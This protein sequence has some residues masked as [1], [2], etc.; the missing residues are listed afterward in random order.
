[1][2]SR[3]RIANTNVTRPHTKN[4]FAL[5]FIATAIVVLAIYVVFHFEPAL[6]T[7]L[8]TRMGEFGSKA[9]T[10][11]HVLQLAF[12]GILAYLIVRA[13]NVL[14]FDLVFRFRRGFEAPTLVRNIFSII[15]FTAL[16]FVIFTVR[17]PGINLGALFTTSAIFGVILGL[18]LQDTLGNFF[19]GISLQADRPFQVGDVITVGVQRHTGVVEE[20]T[21]RAVKIR[22]FQN[23]VVLISNSTA[24]KEPIEVCPRENLNARMH[25]LAAWLV[26][27]CLPG[28]FVGC[29]TP[30]HR[31]VAQP[32]PPP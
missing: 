9:E 21:W 19:A 14:I 10:I 26:L 3:W 16:F 20:I 13:F 2:S 30:G 6:Q 7:L 28:L 32:A 5:F 29:P 11:V 22:T 25:R 15:T 24:A 31:P 8:S 18:A 1:L 4:S 17:F 23:H 27:A 12:V